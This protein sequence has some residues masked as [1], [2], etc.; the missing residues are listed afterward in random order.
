M[1][2]SRESSETHTH[3]SNVDHV[4]LSRHFNLK[5]MA[6]IDPD[7]QD[8]RCLEYASRT[9]YGHSLWK[10]SAAYLAHA[11]LHSCIFRARRSYPGSINF[12][13]GM[14]NSY[15][16]LINSVAWLRHNHRP[17]INV[18]LLLSKSDHSKCRLL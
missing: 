13:K 12:I 4:I 1:D 11:D 8:T 9:L 16:P 14:S 3:D 6:Y 10:K 5:R 2:E 17:M 7:R 18:L 15:A